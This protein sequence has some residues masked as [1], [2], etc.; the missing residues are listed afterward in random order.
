VSFESPFRPESRLSAALLIHALGWAATD[1]RHAISDAVS[2]AKLAGSRVDRLYNRLTAERFLDDGEP[3]GFEVYLEVTDNGHGLGAH[4]LDP[5]SPIAKALNLIAV[6]L[7]VPLNMCRVIWSSDGFATAGATDVL[8]F[9]RPVVDTLEDPRGWVPIDD[10]VCGDLTA[11]WNAKRGARLR[12][13]LVFFQQAWLAHESTQ[14]CLNLAV[15]LES[16][17]APHT[18]GE[19]THQMAFNAAHLIGGSSAQKRE[20]Y[21]LVRKFYGLRSA[22]THGGTPDLDKLEENTPLMFRAVSSLLKRILLNPELA[23]TLE[24]EQQRRELFLRYMFG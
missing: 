12:N 11:A 7:G 15:V 5:I 6:T 22:I 4:P 8:F 9:Y 16:L 3:L 10:T 20:S 14:T 18:Q 24:N 21:V 17:C 13:A 23:A 2:V 19:T 1:R